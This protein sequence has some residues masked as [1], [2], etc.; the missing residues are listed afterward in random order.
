M[1][2]FCP[3]ASGS[4]GNCL[5]LET[6]QTKILIDAGISTKMTRERLNSIGVDLEEIEAILITHEHHDHIQGLRVMAFKLGI[7]LFAN[8][9][10]AKAIV[11]HYNDTAQFTIFTTGETF[12]YK[13]IEVHPFSIQHDAQDPVAFTIL[14][15]KKK[16]G[17]C[18]DLGMATT[19]VQSKLAKCDIL[20]IE[21]NHEPSMVHDS[22][23]PLSYKE[24]VLGRTGHL[25]NDACKELVKAIAHPKLEN[26]FLAH[27]SNECNTHEK[28][29]F[30]TRSG[31]KEMDLNP[32]IEIAYQE[33]VSK[34]IEW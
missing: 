22:K 5:Y 16:M 33:K 32:C 28:A 21:S 20:Y 18:T 3:L 9:E 27:L 4:K 11:R 23:R 19:P 12:N 31:M 2:K 15:N 14:A 30:A 10:T 1:A 17:V 13:D 26:I 34:L 8:R 7:P 25:S 29:L 6:A 24:R